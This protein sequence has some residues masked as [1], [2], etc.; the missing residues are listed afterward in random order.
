MSG[1]QQLLPA[2]IEAV[3][4]GGT[5][6][7]LQAALAAGVCR[8]VYLSTYNVVYGGQRIEAGGAW[9]GRGGEAQYAALLSASRWA[10]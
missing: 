5:R 7:V 1:S 6:A 3:N 10:V 2:V 4:V 9:V 8:L